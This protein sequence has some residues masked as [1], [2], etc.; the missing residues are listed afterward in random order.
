[1][2]ARGLVYEH[3]LHYTLKFLDM[4]HKQWASIVQDSML[5]SVEALAF[6]DYAFLH[7]CTCRTG[8]SI[9]MQMH[10]ALLQIKDLAESSRQFLKAIF[11]KKSLMSMFQLWSINTTFQLMLI[12][13]STL[14][15]RTEGKAAA[16][17]VCIS[18]P[19]KWQSTYSGKS[20]FVTVMCLCGCVALS[21]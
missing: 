6:I 11:G 3:S 20:H 10:A 18:I 14:G 12:T 16:G 21:L 7:Q 2:C 19:V 13:L 4:P 9:L 15:R 17:L 1:M 5:A 8:L